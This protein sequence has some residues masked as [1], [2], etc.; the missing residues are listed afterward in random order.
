MGAAGAFIDRRKPGDQPARGGSIDLRCSGQSIGTLKELQ[1]DL[2]ILS[3]APR[4]EQK[5]YIDAI[6]Y[7]SGGWTYTSAPIKGKSDY[8]NAPLTDAGL[9][10]L[11][12][13]VSRKT[14][15]Y[16]ICD[17]YGGAIANTAADATAFA[18]R[19]GT[20]FCVQYGSNWTNPNDTPQRLAD[21]R[22]FYAAMRPYVSGAAYVNY[23]DVD[24][25]DWQNAYWGQNLARLK[26]IKSTFDPS[27]VFRHAQSVPLA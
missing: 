21:M 23:C 16:I 24:L 20:Q 11:M 2:K 19:K 7:F 13:E 3:S 17:A 18:H 15:I 6:D 12:N 14:D 5:A 10:A 25:T 8:A 27:N 26:Q 4:I 9:A 1:R 22:D